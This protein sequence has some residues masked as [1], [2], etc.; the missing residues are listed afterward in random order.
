MEVREEENYQ[1]PFTVNPTLQ[2]HHQLS[3]FLTNNLN[4]QYCF[5]GFN[6]FHVSSHPNLHS[7]DDF[8][9]ENSFKN[10]NLSSNRVLNGSNSNR[11][12][13]GFFNGERFLSHS[14][15]SNSFGSHRGPI[16]S[17]SANFANTPIAYNSNFERR[18][19]S[20]DELA[21]RVNDVQCWG[22]PYGNRHGFGSS[23][24]SYN[25]HHHPVLRQPQHSKYSSS[26]D[27]LKGRV[28]SVAKDQNGC[29]FL[30]QKVN[31]EKE[32]DM[33]FSEVKDQLHELMVHQFANFLIQKLFEAGNQNQRTELLVWLVKNEQSFMDVCTH[34]TGTRAVQKIME[35]I[36]IP[37]QISILLSVLKPAAVALT[38]NAHGHHIIERCLQIFS[39]EEAEPLVDEIVE[40]CL[41][42]ATD[43]SGCCVLQQCLARSKEEAKERLLVDITANAFVLSEHPYGNYVVQFVLGLREVPHVRANIIVQL[44]GSYVTLSMNKYGSNV[45][46]KCLKDCEDEEQFAGIITEI[47]NDSEFLKVLQDPFGNYVVQSALLVSKG[48]LYNA[49]IERIQHHYP[50]LHSHLYGKKVLAK[51]KG[52]KNRV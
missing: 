25:N 24:S 5:N 10:L 19:H 41:E 3:S 40:H 44:R 7:F 30:Q 14:N 49:F 12:H 46:E 37:N 52:R 2:N 4:S 27:E 23:Q 31:D 15:S 16:T 39:I 20:L 8:S 51:T 21:A 34:S 1:W 35:W 50:F 32:I 42:I 48:D 13:E 38:K 28:S 43:K 9:L 36:S 22:N 11:V 26:L 6:G 33:I 29:R 18:S 45:V 47:M 17:R